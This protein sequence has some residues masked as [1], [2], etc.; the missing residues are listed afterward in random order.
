VTSAT[1]RI[2]ESERVGEKVGG[3][4]PRQPRVVVQVAVKRGTTKRITHDGTPALPPSLPL[5]PLS[6]SLSLLLFLP[7][8]R[9]TDLRFRS[10][11]ND[12]T[13]RLLS[14]PSRSVCP[15]PTR[16]SPSRAS[17][18]YDGRCSPRERLR[19]H[20]WV[21][22]TTHL[23]ATSLEILRIAAEPAHG[24]QLLGKR[25]VD[26]AMILFRMQGDPATRRVHS[27]PPRLRCRPFGMLDE[28]Y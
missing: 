13:S 9:E 2:A 7:A 12:S 28:V 25:S 21:A 20:Q 14:P 27:P 3:I 26:R 23:T 1:R 6:L 24:R 8:P 19:F 4:E 18:R 15:V 17:P 5:L 11:N 10:E 16:P 22:R